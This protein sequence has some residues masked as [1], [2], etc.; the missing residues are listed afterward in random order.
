[1][2]NNKRIHS[3]IKTIPCNIPRI[4]ATLNNM[5]IHWSSISTHSRRRLCRYNLRSPAGI[6]SHKG[7]SVHPSI[8][9]FPSLWCINFHL[10]LHFVAMANKFCKLR[11]ERKR[12]SLQTEWQSGGQLQAGLM[13]QS[14]QTDPSYTWSWYF[15]FASIASSK[16]KKCK[17]PMSKHKHIGILT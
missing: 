14:V 3:N 11:I 16:K 10:D 2:L 5:H 15:C 8:P 9:S 12:S 17:I 4:V 7:D 1:M 13:A 6:G